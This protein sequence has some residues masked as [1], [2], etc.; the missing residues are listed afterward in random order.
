MLH[1]LGLWLFI[2][3]GGFIGG[4]AR[5]WLTGWMARRLGQN[6]PW[7]TLSV[8]VSGALLIGMLSS[9]LVA[10]TSIGISTPD[11]SDMRVLGLMIGLVGSYTTVSSFS[12]QTLVLIRQGKG[13]LAGINVLASVGLTLGAVWLGYWLTQ[14]LFIG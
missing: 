4:L 14:L 5:F 7:G 6:F 12:L 3:L 9:L 13:W 8:N 1:T 10:D 2:G 11:Q